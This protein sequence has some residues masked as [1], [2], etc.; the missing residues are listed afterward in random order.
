MPEAIIASLNGI[1]GLVPANFHVPL[2]PYEQRVNRH[3]IKR[4][5]LSVVK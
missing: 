1:W 2:F 4:W 5:Q 3:T